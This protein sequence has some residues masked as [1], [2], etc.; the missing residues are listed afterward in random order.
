MR[1]DCARR[2]ARWRRRQPRRQEQEN[3]K[4]SHFDS[5][6]YRWTTE[7]PV[8]VGRN[9][10]VRVPWR[11]GDRR[12][13]VSVLSRPGWRFSPA[14]RPLAVVK[15]VKHLSEPALPGWPAANLPPF[16]VT[17]GLDGAVA[18]PG[19]ALISNPGPFSFISPEGAVMTFAF[20][21]EAELVPFASRH[22]IGVTRRLA[23]E[24]PGWSETLIRRSHLT[25]TLP[26]SRERTPAG[27]T[28]SGRS[29]S[30]PEP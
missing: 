1:D 21:H 17:S 2:P 6:W 19:E 25:E 29:I 28:F 24:V 23:A 7:N 14:C 16:K 5:R 27:D 20:H 30:P 15:R 12:P 9:R 4:R 26:S 13:H 8:G 3:L 11:L 22:R 18:G 10:P